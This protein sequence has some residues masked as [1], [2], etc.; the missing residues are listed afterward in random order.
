MRGATYPFFVPRWAGTATSA[1]S[2]TLASRLV[3]KAS[4]CEALGGAGRVE[5]WADHALE[6]LDVAANA[7]SEREFKHAV[8]AN[9]DLG[10]GGRDSDHR[11]GSIMFS[12]SPARARRSKS[13][14]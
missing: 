13:S 1:S 10:K 11:N 5:D 12:V 9:C 8:R 4:C 3:V 7:I 2:P 14:C 6:H